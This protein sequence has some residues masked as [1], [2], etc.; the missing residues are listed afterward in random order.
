MAPEDSDARRAY[1]AEQIGRRHRGW[2]VMWSRWHRTF[3]ASS[4]F[5]PTPLVVDEPTAS[6][7]LAR[8][9]RVEFSQAAAPA[10]KTGAAAPSP[11]RMREFYR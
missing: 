3:T 9:S 8:L 5:S 1:E 6:R 11:T 10:G 4:C 7:M 2:L